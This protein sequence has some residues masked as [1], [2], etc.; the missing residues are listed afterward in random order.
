MS[1]P[2][3]GMRDGVHERIGAS[4]RT[5]S[6]VTGPTAKA[7]FSYAGTRSPGSSVVSAAIEPA[8]IRGAGRGQSAL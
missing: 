3:G 4:P 5:T 7:C 6:G 1:C 2:A 8:G